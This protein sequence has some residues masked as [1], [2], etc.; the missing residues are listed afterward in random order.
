MLL[1]LSSVTQP[2]HYVY[3]PASEGEKF[4]KI[5]LHK[6]LIKNVQQCYR[7]KGDKSVNQTVQILVDFIANKNLVLENAK[8]FLF[9]T[10]RKSVV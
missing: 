3:S 4:K 8:E 2:H 6:D 5:D 1:L 7:F 10:D 9:T